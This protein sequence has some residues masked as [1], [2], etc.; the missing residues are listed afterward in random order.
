VI[1]RRHLLGLLPAV[2]VGAHAEAQNQFAGRIFHRH[3]KK[4]PAIPPLVY[5]G[6]DTDKTGKGIYACRFNEATGQLS[7]PVLAATTHRPAFFALGPLHNGRQFLYVTNEG[8]D[9][10]STVTSW[11]VDPASGALQ[12]VGSVTSGFAGPCY[13][14]VD[15][16]GHSVYVANYS[17]SGVSSFL[18]QPDGSLSAPVERIDFHQP[19]FGT[20]GPNADRQDAPHPHSAMLSP[21]NR[22]LVVNDLGND[23]IA[24]FPIYADT[25]RL[26]APHVFSNHRSGSGPRHVA[27][28]PNGR[29]IYGITELDSKIDQYLWITTHGSQAEALLTDTDHT[30]STVDA[31]YHGSTNTAAE[32][33][34]SN[35][36][37]F[38]YASNR[39]ENSLVVFAIDQT[40][41]ALTLKQRISCGGQGP[42]Q[43][44]FDPT[45]R[46]LLC[47]NQISG[48]V[49]V[50]ARN[51][52]TGELSGPV[53]TLPIDSPMFTM[54][55]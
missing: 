14:S 43:F 3:D 27:F 48:S 51:E 37:F 22:F 20:H 25:A 26:G 32:I 53:Q 36:G 44:T 46:W 41:G 40:T 34:I 21:D 11:L 31:G 23:H 19:V 38:L 35:N 8:D 33:A 50:F 13:I 10:T 47:G 12:P 2:A 6:V 1:T 29:W 24:L 15:A 5:I 45:S 18:I 28:H 16:T 54:F 9:K 52:G 55:A 4:A 39:G 49:T 30:V 42:R 17:G 7:S